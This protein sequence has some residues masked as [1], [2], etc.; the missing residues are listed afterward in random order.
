M[1]SPN[2]SDEEP[3]P[4]KQVRKPSKLLPRFD[5]RDLRSVL[6]TGVT[7]Q[8]FHHRVKHAAARWLDR[9]GRKRRAGI[10]G[11]IQELALIRDPQRLR[12]RA[13]QR[14]DELLHK[15]ESAIYLRRYLEALRLAG[16]PE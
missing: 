2:G 5:R 12:D 6:Y 7:F 14:M 3:Q 10:E 16:L 13:L 8:L 11:V 15:R 9:E 4:R 1:P